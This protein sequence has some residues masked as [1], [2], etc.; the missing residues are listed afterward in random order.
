MFYPTNDETNRP[1]KI[2]AVRL[3][4]T[5]CTNWLTT[6]Q[7]VL[8]SGGCEYEDLGTRTNCWYD[9]DHLKSRCAVATADTVFMFVACV[10]CI[11]AL[12]IPDSRVSGRG[13]MPVWQKEKL[14]L[15]DEQ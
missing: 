8:L 14:E 5:K 1:M 7:N 9:S 15:E 10:V 12:V 13:W 11:G 6:Y 2:F 4:G 3:F